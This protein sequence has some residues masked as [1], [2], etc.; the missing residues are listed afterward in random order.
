MMMACATSSRIRDE[1]ECSNAGVMARNASFC[2]DFPIGLVR[3]NS[4]AVNS[5]DLPLGLLSLMSKKAAGMP[6]DGAVGYCGIESKCESMIN[7]KERER[8]VSTY[9]R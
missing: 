6:S 2:G 5:C 4:W 1:P 7:P 9:E 8:E 3:V